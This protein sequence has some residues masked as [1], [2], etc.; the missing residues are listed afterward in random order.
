MK[1]EFKIY[2]ETDFAEP[3]KYIL[4]LNKSKI[5][6]FQG[7]LGIGKTTFIKY[8]CLEIGVI[9][10]VTSPTFPIIN[11]YITQGNESVF[12]FDFY[13]LDSIKDVIDIGTEMYLS[14]G[15]FCF[16]EWPDLVK[17]L[18]PDNFISISMSFEDD[19]RLI[20]IS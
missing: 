13:R 10:I 18:L 12:H 4:N 3:V 19:C 11:E 15:K 9:D 1:K 16:I 20:K 5:L 2:S 7:D 8:F 17:T 14:S 6:I